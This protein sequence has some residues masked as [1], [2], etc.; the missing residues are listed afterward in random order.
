MSHIEQVLRAEALWALKVASGNFFFSSCDGIFDLFQAI[1]PSDSISKDFMLSSS[2]VSYIISHGLGPY[3][4]FLLVEDIKRVSFYTLEVDETT[5]KQINKHF[6]IQI[7]FWSETSDSFSVC[8]LRAS[9]LGRPNANKLQKEI[10]NDLTKN[11]NY[12]QYIENFVI[13]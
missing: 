4:H 5:I 7:R 3:F 1:F 2:K 10:E 9:F 8:F 13:R 11:W 6:D 12:S